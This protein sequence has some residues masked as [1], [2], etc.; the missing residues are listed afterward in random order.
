MRLCLASDSGTKLMTCRQIKE[1]LVRYDDD[2]T[3]LFV[4]DND[5][6]AGYHRHAY[7]WEPK[8][9]GKGLAKWGGRVETHEIFWTERKLD[10]RRNGPT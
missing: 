3:E 6:G 9:N 7:T 10:G 2:T 4:I 1:V 5:A 8:E